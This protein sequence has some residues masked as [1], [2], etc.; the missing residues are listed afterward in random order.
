VDPLG[1]RPQSE[2][3]SPPDS[4]SASAPHLTLAVIARNEEAV[5][6]RCL[7]SVQGIAQQIVVADTGSTDRTRAIAQAAGAHIVDFPWCNDFSAARNAALQAARGRW[8]LVL[9]ADEFVAPE[10]CSLL[11]EITGDPSPP[12]CAYRVL[13]CS[14]SDGGRTGVV[15]RMVRLFPNRSDVRYEW[16]VH[17]QV[18]LSLERAGVPICD[19]SLRLIHT[20]YSQPEVTVQKQKRN[21]QILETLLASSQSVH[22]MLQFLHGGALLDTGDPAQALDAYRRCESACSPHSELALAARVRQATCLLELE[23]PHEVLPL[24]PKPPLHTCHPEMLLHAGTAALQ[25]G[26]FAQGLE[27]LHAV[28]SVPILPRLPACDDVRVR[29]RAVSE[30]A[31][32]LQPRNPRLAVL[33]M[34]LAS[35]SVQSGTPLSL[36]AVLKAHQNS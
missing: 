19:S 27:W 24:L 15:G 3:S 14:S 22:P 25:L 10:S 30:I 32:F 23:R 31:R 28:L 34:R 16:P 7:D 21:R 1:D 20:G 36:E 9:D 29:A 2:A 35:A 6:K 11:R 12:R 18:D 8:I 33:L 13:N 26:Q 4:A 17:E 5:L